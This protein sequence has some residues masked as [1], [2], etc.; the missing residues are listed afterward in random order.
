MFCKNCGV[1]I[2][3]ETK[4]CPS[5][6]AAVNSEQTIG[7][8]NQETPKTAMLFHHG[9]GGV[10]EFLKTLEPNLDFIWA[11]S[12]NDIK[13]QVLGIGAVFVVNTYILAFNNE[14]LYI[15]QLSKTSGK[16][17]VNIDK[18][19]WREITSFTV[20]GSMVGKMLKFVINNK[21]L[22]FRTQ[23]IFSM[24]NQEDRIE[25]LLHMQK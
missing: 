1:Q 19:A 14:N 4:F 17:I 10:Y 2:S 7:Q 24:E 12:G 22:N 13:A 23:K 15:C 11:R 3:E 20:S 16:K 25:K 5:C 9:S 8:Q 21:K 18:Y 6:G